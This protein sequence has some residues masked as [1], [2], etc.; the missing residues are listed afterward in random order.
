M[1]DTVNDVT[2]GFN[3]DVKDT[4]SYVHKEQLSSSLVSTQSQSHEVSATLI[5]KTQVPATVKL[6]V[7][8]QP[9]MVQWPEM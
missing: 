4:G 2:D 1:C 9:Y 7:S 5:A 8:Y 6:V 3:Q